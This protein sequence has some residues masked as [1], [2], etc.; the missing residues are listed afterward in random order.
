MCKTEMCVSVPKCGWM[1]EYSWVIGISRIYVEEV[2]WFPVD[3]WMLICSVWGI[4]TTC[5][6]CV[7]VCGWKVQLLH[8][9]WNMCVMCTILPLLCASGCYRRSSRKTLDVRV[10]V[11]CVCAHWGLQC[12]GL[13]LS[14]SIVIPWFPL[15]LLVAWSSTHTYIHA[16]LPHH[17][18]NAINA[19]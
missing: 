8:S 4:Y 16:H 12:R 15:P 6:F 10:C 1:F 3:A 13:F 19:T 17:N 9:V 14:S 11:C 2:V 5:L 18:A 7:C